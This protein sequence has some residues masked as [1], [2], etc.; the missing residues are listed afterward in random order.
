MKEIW[1][2]VVGYEGLYKVSNQGRIMSR[3]GK[4]LKPQEDKDG[5]LKIT[6]HNNKRTFAT[7][8]HRIVAI[9]FIPNPNNLPII[10]HKDQSPN[11]KTGLIVNNN[12]ENLEWCTYKYNN[13]YKNANELKSKSQMNRKDVSIEVLQYSLDGVFIKEYASQKEAYRKTGISQANISKSCVSKKYQAGGYMWFFK[14]NEKIPQ[15]VN[16]FKKIGFHYILQF[17]KDGKCFIKCWRCVDDIVKSLKLGVNAGNS[18]RGVCRGECHFAY[19]YNWKYSDEW[20]KSKYDPDA[21]FYKDVVCE[22]FILSEEK[23]KNSLETLDK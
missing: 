8:V 4:I 17:S 9:A 11:K 3:Y 21:V 23:R 5:Y 13:N 20:V 18:I 22:D 19:G 14:E 7:F 6:L 1:R 2:D 10:N 15:F 12:V 16:P